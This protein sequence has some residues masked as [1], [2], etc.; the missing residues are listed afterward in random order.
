MLVG[1]A[2][3]LF[4]LAFRARARR[5]YAPFALGGAAAAALVAGRFVLDWPLLVYVGCAAMAGAAVWNA[6][7]S[8]RA[9]RPLGAANTPHL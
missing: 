1:L 2:A 6:W 4:A 3:A 7:P 9:L 5:G 8:V